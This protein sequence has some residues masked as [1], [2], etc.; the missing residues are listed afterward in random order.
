[1]KGRGGEK[2][3]NRGGEN[4][5]Y[6][7]CIV[8]LPSSKDSPERNFGCMLCSICDWDSYHVDELGELELELDR[9]GG[10][11]GRIEGEDRR[12]GTR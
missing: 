2:G 1:M 9:H 12:G 8:P 5:R 3:E 11:N 4:Y 7:V 6:K 10:E